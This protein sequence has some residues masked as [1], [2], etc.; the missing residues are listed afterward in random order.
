MARIDIEIEDYLDEVRTEY[1]VNEI[2]KRKDAVTEILKHKEIKIANI[3]EFAIPSFNTSED[4]LKY[5]R[6]VLSLKP[7][8]DK[9]RIIQEIEQ[10]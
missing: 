7:W 6:L 8:H 1:L 5:I 2:V 3:D 10:L 9:K 4:V